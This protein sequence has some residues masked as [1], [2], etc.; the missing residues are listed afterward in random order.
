MCV[1]VLYVWLLL[2]IGVL[3]AD[4]LVIRA[5]LSG[6]MLG[7]LIFGSSHMSRG[8]N[9][10]SQ[11]YLHFLSLAT[12]QTL[13]KTLAHILIMATLFRLP[14]YTCCYVNLKVHGRAPDFWRLPYPVY[15]ILVEV[16]Q[17]QPRK[18]LEASASTPST[19]RWSSFTKTSGAWRGWTSFWLMLLLLAAQIG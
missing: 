16:P 9:I 3:S 6:S 7:P 19:P 13:G 4:V 12:H 5:L 14:T 1:C 15:D 17:Q 18:S 10:C 11:T 8:V 2:R